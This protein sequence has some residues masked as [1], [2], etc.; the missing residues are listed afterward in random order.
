MTEQKRR[1]VL[2][3]ITIIHDGREY[4]GH[5]ELSDGMID[6]YYGEK[7]ERTHWSATGDHEALAKIILGELIS[8]P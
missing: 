8:A 2:H 3:S 5:F 7:H 6:V 4:H 1:P